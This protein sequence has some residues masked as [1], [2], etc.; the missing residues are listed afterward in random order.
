MGLIGQNMCQ[1]CYALIGMAA[2]N[3]KAGFLKNFHS[4]SYQFHVHNDVVS[5]CFEHHSN[6][7]RSL[8]FL[9]VHCSCHCG[10]PRSA[11]S[12]TFLLAIPTSTSLGVSSRV[13]PAWR[14]DLL[15]LQLLRLE[16]LSR[17]LQHNPP[18]SV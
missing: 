14:N 7:A 13:K 1:L 8:L 16:R 6:S 12:P 4:L 2:I 17:H 5:K 15:L 11:A 18:A 3:N 10:K 9:Q